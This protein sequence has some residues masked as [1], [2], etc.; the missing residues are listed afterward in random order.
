MNLQELIGKKKKVKIIGITKSEKYFVSEDISSMQ[1]IYIENTGDFEVEELIGKE[2][3][4]L[5]IDTIQDKLIG[6]IISDR[7]FENDMKK[8]EQKLIESGEIQNVQDIY[9]MERLKIK[10]KVLGLYMVDIGEEGKY[11][12]GTTEIG[13]YIKKIKENNI[14]FKSKKLEDE[15]GKQI[16]DVVMSI[17]LAKKEISIKEEQQK[18]INRLVEILAIEDGY[19]ITKVATID[20]N[21]KIEEIKEREE[22]EIRNNEQRI[23]DALNIPKIKRQ[24]TVKDVNIKQELE[25]NEKVTDMKTLGQLLEQNGKM[26]E[27]EGKEFI[28][29]GVI[30]SD[31]RDNLVNSHGERAKVNTTRYSFVA[32]AKDG[33]VVP[34]DLTQD[35]QEGNNPRETNYQVNQ[36]GEVSKDDVLSRFNIGSGTFAVKNGSYGE[37][38]VYHSPRKTIGGKDQEGN[39]SLD[40]ELETNNVWSMKKEERDLAGEYKTGYRSVEKSYQEAKQ[41]EDESG[42]ILPNDEMKTK[43]ID[44]DMKT[45]THAH[46][47]VNYEELATKWGYYEQGKPNAEKAEELFTEKRKQYPQKEQKEIVEMITKELEEEFEHTRQER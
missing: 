9:L 4:C 31:Q 30:E 13:T 27:I 16:R 47:N 21:Q 41:H 46:D 8:I 5:I 22:K 36:K 24:S 2:D 37:I 15:I 23:K 34:L 6:F 1:K 29:M 40:R 14:I 42:D 12:L 7:K 33:T 20:I 43:D 26:P 17:D 3:E 39:Q 32:I 11:Y 45:K 28:Q 19:A 25:M 10:G 44:G 35:H 38:K 18:E